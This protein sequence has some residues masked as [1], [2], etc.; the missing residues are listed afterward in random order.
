M[1][2]QL[3][4]L[5]SLETGAIKILTRGLAKAIDST[6]VAEALRGTDPHYLPSGHIS[7]VAGG[8]VMVLPFDASEHRVL[9]APF[10]ILEGVRIEDSQ[11]AV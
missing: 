10:P 8:I 6:D 11:L 1:G 9:G 2:G 4:S 3:M 7:Y 5:T